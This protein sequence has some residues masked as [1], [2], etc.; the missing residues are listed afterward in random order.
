[1]TAEYKL[2]IWICAG[3]IILCAIT[4]GIGIFL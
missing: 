1:M 4:S 2:V 3:I